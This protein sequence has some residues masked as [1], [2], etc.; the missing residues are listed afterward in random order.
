MV[1]TF[2]CVDTFSG[3]PVL[4]SYRDDF[5]LILNVR[6]VLETHLDTFLGQQMNSENP[7]APGNSP[8]EERP[9]DAEDAQARCLMALKGTRPWV[10]FMGIL[11]AI[12][13]TLAG[14]GSI[15]ALL[16]SLGN[17]GLLPIAVLYGAITVL[18]GFAAKF[19]LFYAGAITRS[20]ASLKLHDI[21]NALEHQKS[22]WKLIGMST[23][24]FLVLYLVLIVM[25]FF[26]AAFSRI[27]FF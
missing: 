10:R 13:A 8:L 11:T 18:Y 24:I 1:N 20:E 14:L 5:G 19:L 25:L 4:Y 16:G 12:A 17:V 6:Q 9:L 26:G 27:G 23:V 3:V 2:I 7:Y 22:F 15:A 21:A